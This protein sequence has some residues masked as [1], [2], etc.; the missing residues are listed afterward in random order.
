MSWASRRRATYLGSVLFVLAVLIAIPVA[1]YFFSIKP[2]C[3]DGIQNQGETA[4]DEGGPCQKLNP[5]DLSSWGSAWARSFQVRPGNYTSIAYIINPN[6]SAG[7]SQADYQFG[8]YDAGNVLVQQVQGTSFILP[9]GITPV[10][11][12]GIDTGNRI[13]V[14]T[15][16]E[17]T[18]ATLDWERMVSPASVVQIGN[19]QVSDTDTSPRIVARATNSS[20]TALSNIK[21]I[22]VVFDPQGNAIAASQT[23]LD[24]LAPNSPQ[25]ITFTWPAAFSGVVGRVDITALLPPAPAPPKQ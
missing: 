24:S 9:G 10:I 11:V 8:L 18:D 14:H 6:D 20:F 5:S 4:A 13:V 25:Q 3:F 23:A 2:T 1:H 12:T 16:F 22:A 17:F 21:F 19:T 15:Y 7:V